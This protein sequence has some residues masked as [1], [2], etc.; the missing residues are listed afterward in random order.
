M[1]DFAQITMRRQANLG[2]FLCMLDAVP[3][4]RIAGKY[5][6]F[7]AVLYVG[8]RG[9]RGKKVLFVRAS[10][11]ENILQFLCFGLHTLEPSARAP[12]GQGTRDTLKVFFL[13]LF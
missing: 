3:P 6:C 10:F 5:A 7:P 12:G 2:A 1:L 11:G 13:L 4:V 9:E 8:G